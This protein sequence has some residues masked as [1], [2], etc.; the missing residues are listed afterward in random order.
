M[1]SDADITNPGSLYPMNHHRALSLFRRACLLGTVI[2]AA[3]G[4]AQGNSEEVV[5]FKTLQGG[6]GRR[7][8]TKANTFA[9]ERTH[10][11]N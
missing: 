8:S 3:A 1:T 11:S 4:S 2:L 10:V 7:G 9:N 5:S 6:E